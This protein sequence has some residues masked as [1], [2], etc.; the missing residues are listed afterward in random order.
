MIRVKLTL[1]EFTKA[2]QVVV[3]RMIE[4]EKQGLNHASTYQR[5]FVE[6]LTEET[7]GA[8]GELA[9]CKAFGWEWSESV[10]TFHE[11]PD[12][13]DNVEVR[14]TGHLDGSLIVRD[15]DDETRWYVLVV[16]KPPNMTVVGRIKGY[17]A[18]QNQ[19][20]RNPHGHRRAWFVPQNALEKFPER[21]VK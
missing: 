18:R 5:N 21:S 13:A 14:S 19:F 15:N 7:I 20:V 11:I 10:N 16:G 8:C 1:D 3:R 9:V 12:V 6:R 2:T 4:S 17:E